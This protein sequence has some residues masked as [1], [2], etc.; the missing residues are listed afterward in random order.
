MNLPNWN[1][2]FEIGGV[3]LE[4][5]TGYHHPS[6][7]KIKRGLTSDRPDLVAIGTSDLIIR[8][9]SEKQDVPYSDFQ[10]ELRR[11]IQENRR[12][13]RRLIGVMPTSA[14]VGVGAL[15]VLTAAEMWTYAVGSYDM[16][17][18]EIQRYEES[19]TLGPMTTRV[20]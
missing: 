13:I 19:L 4:G 20:I 1:S 11:R 12:T 17:T 8:N 14:P 18:P 16:Y 5:T 6:G 10:L 9:L 15:L 2:Y 3:V 7:K